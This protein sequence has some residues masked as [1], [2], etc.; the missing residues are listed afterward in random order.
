MA[1]VETAKIPTLAEEYLLPKK[2]KQPVQNEKPV[3]ETVNEEPANT[4]LEEVAEQKVDEV[5]D[6]KTNE[7]ADETPATE[8]NDST[9]EQQASEDQ[10][11]TEE[12]SEIKLETAPADVRFPTTNQTRHCFT[13]YI[14]YHRSVKLTLQKGRE[15]L[16]A[17]DSQNTIVHFALVNGYFSH[18][19]AYANYS[20]FETFHVQAVRH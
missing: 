5:V 13:R 11:V 20:G 9:P 6:E 19:R 12:T 1:E 3:E 2:E 18:N 14:E 10:E 15:L 4:V 7:Q 16:N 17:T 8:E